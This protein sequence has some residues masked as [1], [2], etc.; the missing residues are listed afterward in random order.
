MRFL[1]RVPFSR[2]RSQVWGKSAPWLSLGLLVAIVV[3]PLGLFLWFIFKT[4]AF[5]VQAITVVDARPHTEEAIRQRMQT[6]VDDPYGIFPARTIFFI[7]TH[8]VEQELLTTLPQVRSLHSTRELPGTVKVVVQEKT[9]VL[10]LLTGRNYFFVDENGIAYEQARLETLPGTVLPVVKNKDAGSRIVLGAPVVSVPF[11]K[12]LTSVQKAL[13][14]V[15]GAEVV[16]TTI[17][18]L[19]AREVS[20]RLSNNWEIHFDVTRDPAGQLAILR[21]LLDSTISADEKKVLEY[22]D[23]RIPNRVYYRVRGGVAAP[24]RTDS[25]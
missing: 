11:V 19:A 17:P 10:L 20:F 3:V 8:E 12:F 16:E 5:R 2:W 15:L 7:D 1:Q 13:P 18:S 25:P 9:P 23:L 14:G 21:T 6:A 22:I 24:V 4:E